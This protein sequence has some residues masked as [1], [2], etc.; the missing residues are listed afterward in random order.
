[1]FGCCQTLQGLDLPVGFVLLRYSVLCTVASLSLINLFLYLDLYVL[2]V[3]A[4]IS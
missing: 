1:M 2:G 3:D 4:W